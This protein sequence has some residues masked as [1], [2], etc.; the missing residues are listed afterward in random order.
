LKI[1]EP[2]VV[3][4]N[5]VHRTGIDVIECDAF[6]DVLGN[7]NK[8]DDKSVLHPLYNFPARTHETAWRQG[9]NAIPTFYT[10]E[11]KVLK[12]LRDIAPETVE[13]QM[14]LL[15]TLYRGSEMSLDLRIQIVK[16]PRE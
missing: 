2:F 10:R 13:G 5:F 16:L 3:A 6:K 11:K 1:I 14:S 9:N 8:N 12:G 15:E 7:I 4:K